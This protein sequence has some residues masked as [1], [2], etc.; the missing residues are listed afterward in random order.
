MTI[1][2]VLFAILIFGVLIGVHELGHF[3]TA[4]ACNVRVNEFSIGMGPALWKKRRGETLYAL[5][6]LP[7]G[8]Y[9]AL[10]GEDEK[11]DDPRAFTNQVAWKR[12]LILAAGAFMNFV[13]G[14]VIIFGLY[15][16]AAAFRSPT[17]TAFMDGCPYVGE[18]A[19][20]EGDR[21]YRIDGHR[22]YQQ[23][24]VADFLAQGDGVYDLVMIRDGRKVKLDD[25]RLVPVQLEGQEK[26]MYGFYLGSE[27][28][29]LAVKLRYTWNTAMEFSRLVWMSLGMLVRGQVSVSEMSGPVGL[30]DLM[31]ETGTS[32]ASARIGV[33]NILYLAAL[34]AVNLAIMNLLPIPALD[35][36]R[37][38]S[39][40]V[41][42]LIESVSRRRLDPRYEGY[43]HA[44]GMVLLLGLMVVVMF[45]DILRIITK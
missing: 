45:N 24:D 20:Q 42:W 1:A 39:L 10:A 9:C 18:Q 17:I 33:F 30:V 35:G 4:K 25:F 3:L 22:I 15:F 7:F 44:A 34:L 38:F 16:N 41:I 40:L 12:A 5:R 21:F 26:E 14:L 28:A 13:L 37:I 11:S 8:G 32:A 31:A 19:L 29:T 43:V 23:Y 27:K 6:L 36:G 2:Y